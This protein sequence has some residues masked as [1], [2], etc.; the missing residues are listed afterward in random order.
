MNKIINTLNSR[1]FLNIAFVISLASIFFT[2]SITYKHIVE[3]NSSTKLVMKSFEV[4]LELEKLMSV[5][6]DAETGYSG[7]LLYNDESFL[8]TFNDSRASVDK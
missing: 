3:V 8:E 6:K 4:K 7:Y 5:L 1:L 2:A